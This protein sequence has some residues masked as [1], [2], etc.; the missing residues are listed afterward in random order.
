[1][2]LS[3]CSPS[4]S[5]SSSSSLSV[6]PADSVLD[7]SHCSYWSYWSSECINGSC[8]STQR[9][10]RQ[11]EGRP[12]EEL[13]S[14]DD[15][16]EH[17]VKAD[18]SAADERGHLSIDLSFPDPV[19]SLFDEMRAQTQLMSQAFRDA[20]GPP[21]ARPGRADT[22]R[23][24][25]D[26]TDSGDVLRGSLFNGLVDALHGASREAVDALFNRR[27]PGK[28]HKPSDRSAHRQ[29]AWLAVQGG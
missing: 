26:D 20:F 5:P 29:L 18:D 27:S 14:R 19:V 25:S 13:V 10:F 17:W 21:P 1:M 3:L 22:P 4:S 7:S 2:L 23:T 11:C 16:A 8:E 24:D 12:R 15:G 6:S 9:R 28:E